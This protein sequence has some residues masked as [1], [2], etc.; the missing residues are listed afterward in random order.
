[1]S[2]PGEFSCVE[3]NS[4]FSFIFSLLF[5]SSLSSSLFC[6]SLLFHLLSSLV[7][8]SCLVSSCGVVVGCG[9]CLV[10]VLV[11]VCCGTVKNVKKTR[12]HVQNAS[13]CTFK[14]PP[15]VPAPSPH[16]GN[17]WLGA[18]THGGVLNVHTET[19]SMQTPVPQ[20]TQPQAAHR[21]Q[22]PLLMV[23]FRQCLQVLN[24]FKPTQIQTHKQETRDRGRQTETDTHTHKHTQTNTQTNKHIHTRTTTT[25][26]DKTRQDK[27]R[28]DET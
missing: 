14:T 13:V 10:C 8:P 27:T 19:R 9:V 2:G 5:L 28:Q 3:S 16:V 6:F 22:A 21:P 4:L 7:L 17:M 15:C 18:G 11:F 24:R 25:P 23:P 20:H 26:Q 1:M 12:V